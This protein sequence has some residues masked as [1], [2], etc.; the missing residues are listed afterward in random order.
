MNIF[1][2]LS[3][4]DQKL[5][6]PA[7]TS[8]LAFLL[9]PYESHGL[10]TKFLEYFIGPVVQ[11]E[12]HYEIYRDLVIKK[13][14]KLKIKSN[15]IYEFDVDVDVEVAKY[16]TNEDLEDSTDE[17][18]SKKKR[19]D[20]DI[21]IQISSKENE[22]LK[23]HFI[24]ENK[25]NDGAIGTKSNQLSNQLESY[26]NEFEKVETENICSI[27]LTPN[28]EASNK[29]FNQFHNES[30]EKFGLMPNY[31]HY[32]KNEKGGI[33]LF[34]NDILSK[35]S[36]GMI[37][38][39]QDYTKHTLKAF[40]NFIEIGFKSKS[41]EKD[42]SD[43]YKKDIYYIEGFDDF[44]KKYEN[45][46]DSSSWQKFIE[47]KD[48]I[49]GLKNKDILIRFSKTHYLACFYKS[50]RI[51][52]LSSYYA[53]KQNFAIVLPKKINNISFEEEKKLL[54]DDLKCIYKERKGENKWDSFIQT[55]DIT[56][57]QII[58]ILNRIINKLSQSL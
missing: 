19:N 53:P 9:D 13:D 34:L 57:D 29:Y 20:I 24:V 27:F 2:I 10:K 49:S 8:F 51:F 52:A 44:R 33:Y 1:K 45:R 41:D 54:S 39:L 58:S 47:I 5:K 15:F 23:Y 35:E 31:H 6:E 40:M 21:V 3:S 22:S 32:W 43:T 11:D 4:G 30:Q 37:E 7:V 14:G 26:L 55:E 56:S 38:P 25:L 48:K 16:L 50:T 17:N 36:V 42:E 12:K 28:T 46:L 18:K